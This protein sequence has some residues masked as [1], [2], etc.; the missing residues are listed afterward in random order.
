MILRFWRGW[1][2]PENAEAYEQLLRE[3]IFTGIEARRVP[4]Y[5]G[6]EMGRRVSGGEVE[7]VT[8]MRFDDLESVRGFSGDDLETAVVPPAARALL[9]R[10]DQRSAH[11]ELVR[12]RPAPVR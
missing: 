2:S 6:I 9:A 10:F 1:T 8:L 5:R 4:G 7:F 3:E 12:E 11:Y